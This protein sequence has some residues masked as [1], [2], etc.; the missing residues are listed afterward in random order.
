MKVVWRNSLIVV[1]LFVSMLSGS[2]AKVTLSKGEQYFQPLSS[3]TLNDFHFAKP[4]VYM[5]I[6]SFWTEPSNGEDFKLPQD[7]TFHT[8]MK[9]GKLAMSEKRKKWAFDYLAYAIL[10]KEY[11]WKTVLHPASIYSFTTLRFMEA[12]DLQLK[13]VT[14]SQDILD[15]FGTIDT[16]AELHVWIETMYSYRV[17]SKPYSWKRIKNLYR[18]RFKGLNPFTCEYNEYFEYFNAKGKKVRIQNIRRYRKKDCEIIMI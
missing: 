3:Y 18:V 10:K 2:E 8:K 12:D 15:L 9:V 17:D 6:A 7:Y 11:F 5:D 4:I 13:A 16:E 14:E 1:M